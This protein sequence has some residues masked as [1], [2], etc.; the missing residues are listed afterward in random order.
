[1]VA[2]KILSAK[3]FRNSIYLDFEGRKSIDGEDYPL[4]HM[5]GIFRPNANGKSGVYPVIFFK[6]RWKPAKNGSGKHAILADFNEYFSSLIEELDHQEKHIVYW[7][8]HEEKMLEKHLSSNTFDNLRPYLYNVHPL[9]KRYANRLKKFGPE[10]TA[11]KKTL[12][13]FFSVLYRKRKPYPPLKNGPSETCQ[14]IDRACA[15]TQRWRNFTE[16]QKEYVKALLAYNEGDCRGT[17]LIAKK[18]GN[19]YAT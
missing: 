7:T 15:N 14:R 13:E 5:A 18:V 3:S 9:A 2:K 1:M 8:Q 4:P 19:F 11:R 6:P 16:R 10:G 12:E 17:W